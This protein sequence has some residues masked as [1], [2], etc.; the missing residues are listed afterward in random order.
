MSSLEVKHP[1][2][3][4]V[5]SVK[6]RLGSSVNALLLRHNVIRWMCVC[7]CG[8]VR[9][10]RTRLK[11]TAHSRCASCVSNAVCLLLKV[12]CGRFREVCF[13]RDNWNSLHCFLAEHKQTVRGET[14]IAPTVINPTAADNQAGIDVTI[15]LNTSVSYTKNNALTQLYVVI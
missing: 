12:K 13:E 3:A 11:P 9:Q 1:G 6:D 7:V 8:N 14:E 10:E 15:L 4:I 5:S 2:S